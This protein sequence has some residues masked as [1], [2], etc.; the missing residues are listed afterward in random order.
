MLYSYN[1]I[2]FCS[3][4]ANENA[5]EILSNI[6][7]RQGLTDGRRLGY[8]NVFTKL[9]E[10]MSTSKEEFFISKEEMLCWSV[11]ISFLNII[12]G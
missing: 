9:I 8:L 2:H 12:L 3:L 6:C 4:G 11:M 7:K 10:Q 1:L 5:Y